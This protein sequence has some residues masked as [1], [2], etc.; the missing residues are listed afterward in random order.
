MSIKGPLN[1]SVFIL[2][3]LYKL[4]LSPLGEY[5]YRMLSGQFEFDTSKFQNLT[6]WK[7]TK[8]NNEMLLESYLYFKENKGLLFSKDVSPHQRVADAGIL[9]LLRKIS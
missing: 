9:N 6:N 2:K 3:L 5:Q 4:N 8:T 1:C 7:A